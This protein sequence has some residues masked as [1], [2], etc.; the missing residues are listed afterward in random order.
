VVTPPEVAA[1][2]GL[3]LAYLQGFYGGHRTDNPLVEARALARRSLR[4]CSNARR[5]GP[6]WRVAAVRV[7]AQNLLG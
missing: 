2:R 5:H 4:P 1:S 7:F 6:R 3:F